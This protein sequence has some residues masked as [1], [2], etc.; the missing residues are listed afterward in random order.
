MNTHTK[1]AQEVIQDRLDQSITNLDNAIKMNFYDSCIPQMIRIT[2]LQ[3]GLNA[4]N[5]QIANR[6]EIEKN[7]V[8]TDIQKGLSGKELSNGFAHMEALETLNAI[9][10]A[11]Q[12]S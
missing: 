4:T 1:T 11:Y 7:K 5:E 3:W 6:L 8:I 9:K 10:K 2:T 12:K